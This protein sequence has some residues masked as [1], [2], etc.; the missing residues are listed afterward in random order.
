MRSEEV[1]SLLSRLPNPELIR[2][3][4]LV[5]HRTPVGNYG[6]SHERSLSSKSMNIVLLNPTD[7]HLAG[8]DLAHE[9]CHLL[10]YQYPVER[11]LFGLA[12]YVEQSGFFHDPQAAGQPEENWA[13]HLTNYFLAP[14]D[15]SL[16]MLWESAPVRSLVLTQAMKKAYQDLPDELRN[17]QRDYVVRLLESYE[18]R[19]RES[20]LNQ[21]L[22]MANWHE[23]PYSRAAAKLIVFLG[24]SDHFSL[25]QIEELDLSFQPVND[26]VLANV[27]ECKTLRRL[28]L[29]G[30]Q[31]T[32]R[33]ITLLRDLEDLA[34]LSLRGTTIR[35]HLLAELADFPSLSELSLSHTGLSDAS[36]NALTAFVDL[37]NL[38]LAGNYFSAEALE[39]LQ[40][41]LPN[42][43]VSANELDDTPQFKE[44][45]ENALP[46][47]GVQIFVPPAASADYA[48]SVFL[49]QPEELLTS[50]LANV[51]NVRFQQQHPREPDVD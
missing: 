22:L 51:R 13:T 44:V 33:G 45:V 28:S 20:T 35:E 15:D 42:C 12:A 5:D 25:L 11:F 21:L 38:Y 24:E 2:Q 40:S 49:Q 9:W 46:S 48:Q 10:A 32:A 43:K 41:R 4:V 39:S 18:S 50:L 26:S 37:Q 7:K 16:T 31:V 27:A 36:I 3:V 30:T 29:G 1:F 19:Y 8:A 14:E 47:Q 17:E 23:D 34:Y 6:T